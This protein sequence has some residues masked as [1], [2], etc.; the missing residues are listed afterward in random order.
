MTKDHEPVLRGETVDLLSSSGSGLFVDATLGAGGHAAAL[1]ERDSGNRLIGIDRDGDALALVNRRDGKL[2]LCDAAKVVERIEQGMQRSTDGRPSPWTVLADRLMNDG[3]V[4]WATDLNA[5][6]KFE[7]VAIAMTPNTVVALGKSQHWNRAHPEWW[8]TAVL[9]QNGAPIGFWRY[10]LPTPPLP[11]G[12]MVGR[13]GQVVVA[14]LDGRLQS[15]GPRRPQTRRPGAGR[16]DA[17]PG[18]RRDTRPPVRRDAPVR[19]R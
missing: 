5:P 8:L 6:G 13:E 18:A 9:K 15:F 19:D 1:L 10:P 14:M 16:G 3:G 11:E 4:R 12:L 17:R 2:Q 7:I